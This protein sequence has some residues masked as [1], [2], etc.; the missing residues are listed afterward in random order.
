V[1]GVKFPDAAKLLSQLWAR[2]KKSKTELA[3]WEAILEI[4]ES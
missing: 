1:I 2:G 4:L 3:D